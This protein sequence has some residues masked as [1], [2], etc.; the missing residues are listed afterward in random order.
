MSTTPGKWT[1]RYCCLADVHFARPY[2]GASASCP[3][4]TGLVAS[5]FH[6]LQLQSTRVFKATC[7]Q[8]STPAAKLISIKHAASQRPS[9][10]PF[11]LQV[12]GPVKF[13]ARKCYGKLCSRNG[14]SSPCPCW[15]SFEGLQ[16]SR[17]CP[18]SGTGGVNYREVGC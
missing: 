18:G 8:P 12:S 11:L 3:L 1:A 14:F 4:G 9:G 16:S 13:K 7:G 15:E 2:Q 6:V 5:A 17:Q 10:K